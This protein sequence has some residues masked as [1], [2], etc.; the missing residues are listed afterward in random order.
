MVALVEDDP[1]QRRRLSVLLLP[2]SRARPV[3]GRLGQDQGVVGDDQV[4]ATAGAYG[5]FD[6]TGAVVGTGGV[7]ALAPPVDQIGRTRRMGGRDGEQA[8]QP[9]GEVAAG[10]VPVARVQGP[11]S[12]QAQADQVAAPQLGRLDHV[13]KIEDAQIV[14]APLADHRLSAALLRIGPQSMAFPVD[15]ALQGPRIGRDPGRPLV[16][17]G[18][19]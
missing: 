9:A 18:P 14:L 12:G 15:L 1:L 6:E 11:A 7:D 2:P 10:H 8:R 5:L 16:P 13:L 3:E 17:L 4:G 19:E